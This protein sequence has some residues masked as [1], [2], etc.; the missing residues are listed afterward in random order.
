MT[1]G[2]G[3]SI[4]VPVIVGLIMSVIL[5]EGIVKISINPRE[6]GHMTKEVRH[7]RVFVGLVIVSCTDGVHQGL[8]KIAVNHLVSEVVVTL[9]PIIFREV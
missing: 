2:L 1:K 7:L 3:F 4:G 5:V 9:L 8:V 6:L